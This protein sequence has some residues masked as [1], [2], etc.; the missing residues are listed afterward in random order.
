M[1]KDMC[2]ILNK[3]PIYNDF[4]LV[5]D[6]IPI[7]FTCIDDKERYYV[8]ICVD[9]DLPKYN[10]VK[11]TLR[12]LSDMLQGNIS[13]RDI[14]KF[15]HNYWEVLPTDG[16]IEHDKVMVKKIDEIDDEDLPDENAYFKLYSDSL[17]T[18]ASKIKAK[19]MEGKYSHISVDLKEI[20]DEIID[21]K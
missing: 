10:V 11:V 2:F 14:F 5:R 7:F 12:Q 15:Q 3:K 4:C 20:Q 21:R 16:E 13:M 17:V 1:E 18:Y 6:D 19:V 8:A 9:M